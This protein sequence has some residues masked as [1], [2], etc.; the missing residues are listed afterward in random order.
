[1]PWMPSS[2]TE[3][4]RPG[5][6]ALP[7]GGFEMEDSVLW[8]GSLN[9]Y[10]PTRKLTVVNYTRPAGRVETQILSAAL[11]PSVIVPTAVR[12]DNV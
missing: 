9:S 12:M 10:I 11:G 6:S 8:A 2:D 3:P 1:M 5:L 7:L 4:V